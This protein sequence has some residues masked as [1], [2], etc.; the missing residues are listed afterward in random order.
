MGLL[1]RL[2]SVVSGHGWRDFVT[3]NCAPRRRAVQELLRA[4]IPG[5]VSVYMLLLRP[6]LYAHAPQEFIPTLIR[7][8][9]PE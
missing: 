4:A 2:V 9:T 5:V 1:V 3:V 6:S 7:V 8:A